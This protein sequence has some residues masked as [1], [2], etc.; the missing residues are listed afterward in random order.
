MY[1]K[2][3]LIFFPLELSVGQTNDG[4]IAAILNLAKSRGRA[5]TN[6]TFFAGEVTIEWT[7]NRA[8]KRLRMPKDGRGLGSKLVSFAKGFS[9]HPHI[10]VIF[11][12]DSGYLRFPFKGKVDYFILYSILVSTFVIFLQLFSMNKRRRTNE[13]SLL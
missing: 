8:E 3:Q 12:V 11:M 5:S 4:G 13:A 10:L 2:P 9:K 1:A 7:S 6:Q